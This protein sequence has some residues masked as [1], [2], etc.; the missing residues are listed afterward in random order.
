MGR[1]EGT[2]AVICGVAWL[3][4]ACSRPSAVAP[5]PVFDLEEA[6]VASLED[7]MAKGQDTARSI[8]EKYLGRIEA[9]DRQ[10]PTLRSVIEI[11]PDALAIAD[12]LDA[13]RKTRGPRGPFHG[14]PVLIK[15]NIATSDR[16]QTTSASDAMWAITQ[17][18]PVTGSGRIAASSDLSSNL[19]RSWTG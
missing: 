19:C 2:A 6:T 16:M 12:G 17:F 11:N 4:G 7:R 8:A 3:S 15:D 5:A 9:I 10:G 14:I 1:S 13:E 18:V